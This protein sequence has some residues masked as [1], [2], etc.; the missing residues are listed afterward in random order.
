[1]SYKTKQRE[2]LLQH[3][4]RNI[5]RSYSAQELAQELKVDHISLSAIYRNLTSMCE[6]GLLCKVLKNNNT[7]AYYQFAHKDECLG[8][9]HLK[10]TTCEE[11]YHL[12][13]KL[14][15]LIMNMS[16]D[17]HSFTLDPASIFLY[18]SCKHCTAN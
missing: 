2:F 16:S 17:Q 9:I 12:D 1:M 15:R 11:T 6:E 7:T 10:C 13:K 5:H 8:I 14:S 3:F 4:K 18:G